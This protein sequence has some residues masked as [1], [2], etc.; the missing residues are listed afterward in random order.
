MHPAIRVGHYAEVDAVVHPCEAPYSPRVRLRSTEADDDPTLSTWEV[1]RDDVTRVFRVTTT[2]VWH[3]APVE[4]QALRVA[5]AVG[6]P[7][8]ARRPG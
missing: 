8:R 6:C 5:G 7:S 4:V 2:A 1:D 3:D